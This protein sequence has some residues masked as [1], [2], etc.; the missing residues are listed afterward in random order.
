MRQRQRP[1]GVDASIRGMTPFAR[2]RGQAGGEAV[3]ALRLAFVGE[4]QCKRLGEAQQRPG[5]ARD[6][7]ELDL[8]DRLAPPPG[9]DAPAVDGE[10]GAR[11]AVDLHEPGAAH[12]TRLEHRLQ[13]ACE[14]HEVDARRAADL[15][16]RKR[17]RLERLAAHR[18]LPFGARG[19][20]CVLRGLGFQ[21]LQPTLAVAPQAQ[22]DA[23]P[24]Q[25]LARGVEVDAL[26]GCAGWGSAAR[27]G[28]TPA[29]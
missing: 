16:A 21:R 22:R 23:R 3:A 29:A 15:L 2:A 9:H 8:A 4:R 11:L 17:L 18:Q 1:R 27:A 26:R 10:L 20:P 7:L 14:P 6:E 13:P 12:K 28:S 25:L 24:A 19:E 5:V